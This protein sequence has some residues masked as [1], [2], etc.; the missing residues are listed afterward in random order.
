MTP[1]N[2]IAPAADTA[3][4]NL[5]E[6]I[7]RSGTEEFPRGKRTLEIVGKT[8]QFDMSRPVITVA[9]RN[10]GYKFLAAEA[11]WI[12]SGS[13]R[14]SDIAPYS[15][16]ISNFSDDGLTFRGA[17]GPKIMDQLP[18]VAEQFTKDLSTRQAVLTIWRERPGPSKDY[19]C[20]LGAQW[21]LRQIDG[22]WYMHCQVTMRSS[23]A[24]LGSPYDWFN[25]SIQT[26]FLIA[27]MR[28][29]YPET[30]PFP[31]NLGKMTFT[32]GSQHLYEEHI[33]AAKTCVFEP[34]PKFS[35]VSL[36][37]SM[38]QQDPYDF[39]DHI[40]ALADRDVLAS[41]FASHYDTSEL[42]PGD[43]RLIVRGASDPV[44]V[45]AFEQGYLAELYTL[46]ADEQKTGF[47]AQPNPRGIKK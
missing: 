20:T 7:T 23:D 44:I 28:T 26:A 18:W 3:W 1:P 27:Y 25:F 29:A 4:L 17:Y 11:W 14:V 16:A 45:S 31:I 22:A 10:L 41:P 35:Y 6:H 5:L 9:N 12:A 21:L 32:A 37:P 36:N 34:D 8:T 33:E 19:P 38:Y 13:N 24:W 30:F 2:N 39:L 40:K 47:D 42:P 15:K 43:K 46:K